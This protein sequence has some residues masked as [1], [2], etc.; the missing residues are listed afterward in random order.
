[1]TDPIRIPILDGACGDCIVE[2]TPDLA[3]QIVALAGMDQR[4]DAIYD[5]LADRIREAGELAKRVEAMEQKL[6]ALDNEITGDIDR[7]VLLLERNLHQHAHN[8]DGDSTDG[9][10]NLDTK[11]VDAGP[12]TPPADDAAARVIAK[13][14]EKT[15]SFGHSDFTPEAEDILAAIR[16]GKVPGIETY[17]HTLR[18]KYKCAVDEVTHLRAQ[19]AEATAKL[20]SAN[21]AAIRQEDGKN[22]ALRREHKE[23]DLRHAAEK[24]RDEAR[25]EVAALKG[26]KVTLPAIACQVAPHIGISANQAAWN[27][28]IEQC[29]DA[30]RAAGV[31]VT[32]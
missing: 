14:I 15:K 30:I 1:V 7:R 19:L 3:R 18:A 10:Y 26:R 28:A 9:I 17:D 12:A 2:I 27:R 31:E 11:P 25:A 23:E 32:P 6:S 24:Q 20:E 8:V 29:A 4:I 5:N 21:Q 22:A 13:I 16:Q